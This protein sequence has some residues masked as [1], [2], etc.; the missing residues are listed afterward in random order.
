MVCHVARM[1][2]ATESSAT[3]RRNWQRLAR[4]LATAATRH[5]RVGSRLFLVGE[6]ANWVIDEELKAVE[7]VAR[8]LGV[9]VATRRLLSSSRGQAAF[10]GSN[11]TLLKEPWLPPSHRLG[12]TYFH[13]R[14]GTPGMPEFDVPYGILRAHHERLDRIQVSHSEMEEIVLESG[15]ASEKVHRIPIGVDTSYF[16]PSTAELRAE[17]RRSL[18]LPESAFVVG[19]FQKDGVGWKDGLEPKL[20]KGPDVLAEALHRARDRVPDLHVLLSGPA[21]GYVRERLERAGVPYVHRVLGRYEE[22]AGLYRALD[23]YLVASRQEGGPKAV[24]ESMASGVPLVTTRVGQ[25]MDLVEHGRNA[26]MVEPED[27]DGLSHWLVHIAEGASDLGALRAA[28][29]QT[30]AENTYDAQAP[31]WRALLTG[32]VEL[33]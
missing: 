8:D 2:E 13:G 10:Y 24:L 22:V 29:V 21:R 18:G 33:G 9:R 19:S 25:A 4:P 32:F 1:T 28:G 7:R 23:A 11:F 17:V 14:P 12:T 30:A 6:Q 20:V 27:V 31:L 16:R 5:W 15:I 26:Y 3:S